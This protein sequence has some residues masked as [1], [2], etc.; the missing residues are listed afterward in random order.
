VELAGPVL[1]RPVELVALGVVIA[2]AV[3]WL[4]RRRRRR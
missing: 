3:A 4:L 2:G 1:D